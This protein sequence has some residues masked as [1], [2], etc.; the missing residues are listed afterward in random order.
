MFISSP[1]RNRL[2][3]GQPKEK[4]K[5]T[6]IVHSIQFLLVINENL[7]KFADLFRNLFIYTFL[8]LFCEINHVVGTYLQWLPL[9]F[10]I[11]F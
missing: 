9:N 6:F 8:Q 10:N 11:C 3:T 7:L 1:H 5:T 2:K 4:K